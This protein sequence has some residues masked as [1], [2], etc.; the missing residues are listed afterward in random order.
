MAVKLEAT[1]ASDECYPALTALGGVV[2]STGSFQSVTFP[3]DWVVD[4][5]GEGAI[6]DQQ[7]RRRG[8]V[9][10]LGR[11]V[12]MIQLLPYFGVGEVTGAEK[13]HG[14][15]A[16]RATN[17]ARETLYLATQPLG[18]DDV[19]YGA[20]GEARDQVQRWLDRHYPNWRDLTAYWDD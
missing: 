15:C 13:P 4:L 1:I 11:G 16:A 14:T 3:D 7:G 12:T 10:D 17:P 8:S 18:I 5:P 19:S 9:N 2:E 20:L 6:T